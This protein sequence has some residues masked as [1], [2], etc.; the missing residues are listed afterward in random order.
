[1]HRP[2]GEQR[3]AADHERVPVDDALDTEALAVGE[4][5]HGRQLAPGGGG[6]GDGLRDGVLGGV[7]ERADEA[8]RLG[9]VDAVG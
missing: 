6:L 1:M 3:G 2:V 8:Q 5:L 4:A 7:F 9:A